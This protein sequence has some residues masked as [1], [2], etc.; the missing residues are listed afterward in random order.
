VQPSPLEIASPLTMGSMDGIFSR[1][2]AVRGKQ[3]PRRAWRIY[4]VWKYLNQKS[5]QPP[6]VNYM[7]L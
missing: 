4:G 2:L 5:E 7:L 1:A 6:L 3:I